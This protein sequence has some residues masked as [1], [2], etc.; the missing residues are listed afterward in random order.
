MSALFHD[1]AI[2]ALPVAIVLL[3]LAAAAR[4][5]V[6][7]SVGGTEER[8]A[9]AYLEPLAL[10]SV[11]AFAVHVVAIGAAGEAGV[12]SVGVPLVL[13]VVAALLHPAG[14]AVAREALEADEH[15]PATARRPA[16]AAPRPPAA[17]ASAPTS[18]APAPTPSPPAPAAPATPAAAPAGDRAPGGALWADGDDDDR[19]HPAGLWSRA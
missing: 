7:Q 5:A 12:V 4:I 10:W 8:L 16:T 1:V 14:E 17:A 13:G 15:A 18:A 6:G 3:L 11:G 19:S 9:R 2:A